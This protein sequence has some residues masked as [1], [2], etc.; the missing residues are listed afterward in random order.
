MAFSINVR[1]YSPAKDFEVTGVSYAGAPRNNTAMYVSHKVEHLLAN[2]RNDGN[3]LV[4]V[5]EQTNVP[6]ELEGGNVFVRCANPQLEYVRFAD[7]YAKGLASEDDAKK[8]TL[9]AGGY[10]LGQDATVGNG[11]II[12]PGCI[13]G[14]GVVIG[15]DSRIKAGAVIR[16]AVIGDCCEICENCAIGTN[17]FTMADDEF[18]NKIRIPSLGKVIIGSNVE[19]GALTNISRGSAGNTVID[20]NVKIDS[21]VHI[22]HDAHLCRNAEITAGAIIGGFAVVNDGVFVG[23]NSAIR[24]RRE[25]GSDV[26]IG[27]GSTVIRNID[28]GMTVAGNPAKEIRR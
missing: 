27:M 7:E 15:H 22:G 26:I 13:I 17:G 18:G 20:D 3:C 25:I 5:D 23:I 28:G 8:Y 16:N 24:N 1:K 4:F 12:E 9:T 19:I 10:Y 11:T 21:L 14:H 6:P 2:L